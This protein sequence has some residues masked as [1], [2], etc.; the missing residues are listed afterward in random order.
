MTM[1]RFRYSTRL[2]FAMMLVAA[3]LT[4]LWV[5]LGRHS[6]SLS[7]RLVDREFPAM[8]EYT[9]SSAATNEPTVECKF[10]ELRF[11]LP[12]TMAANF[13]IVRPQPSDVSLAFED[14]RRQM[15][16]RLSGS[17]LRIL[18]PAIP[19][20]L[21]SQTV[22]VLLRSIASAS[23]QDFSFVLTP[24]QVTVHDWAL[25]RR[26]SLGLAIR[27]KHLPRKDPT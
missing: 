3:C 12:T 17:D 11:H 7:R 13:R 25:A 8:N 2:L 23:T 6:V 26:R 27:L 20:Q 14:A 9:F 4:A 1:P 5:R 15:Q 16:I 22:P 10:R 18:F 19:Q 24:D 21:S